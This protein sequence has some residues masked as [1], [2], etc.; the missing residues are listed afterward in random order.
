MSLAVLPSL[1]ALEQRLAAF[2]LAL[3][4]R[5]DAAAKVALTYTTFAEWDLDLARD[6]GKI[7]PV[8]L[9]RAGKH[10]ALAGTAVDVAH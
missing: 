7:V 5:S 3:Y 9:A 4:G 1:E 10:L 2:Q 6:G 8:A